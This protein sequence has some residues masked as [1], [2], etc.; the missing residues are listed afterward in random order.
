MRG[1]ADRVRSSAASLRDV[2]LAD[3]SHPVALRSGSSTDSARLSH[4]FFQP[5]RPEVG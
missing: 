2:G 4:W 1:D 3:K 5:R